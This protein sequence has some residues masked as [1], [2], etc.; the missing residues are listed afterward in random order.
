M[1]TKAH[2]GSTA[3]VV[4]AAALLHS[5]PAFAQDEALGTYTTSTEVTTTPTS[6]TGDQAD[7]TSGGGASGVKS[8]SSDVKPSRSSGAVAGAA[9]GGASPSASGGTQGAGVA[10]G[11]APGQLAF[12]GARPLVVGGFGL[13]LMGLAVVLQRR[14][15]G[16]VR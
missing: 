5:G 12:T 14:R 8:G 6:S 7:A 3:L 16:P 4:C 13:L 9:S 15:T 11:S 2:K 10:A 1:F